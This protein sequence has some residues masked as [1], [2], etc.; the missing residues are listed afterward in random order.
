M[1][2]IVL[3]LLVLIRIKQYLSYFFF[4]YSF[5]FMLFVTRV[6]NGC[7]W[8]GM[9]AVSVRGPTARVS[10]MIKIHLKN[11]FQLLLCPAFTL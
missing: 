1:I 6:Y 10:E 2:V 7:V 8:D 5:S 9:L 11:F 3:S 4:S